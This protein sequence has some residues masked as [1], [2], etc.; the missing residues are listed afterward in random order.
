MSAGMGDEAPAVKDC[1]N[2]KHLM[3]CVSFLL[4]S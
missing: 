4:M 1:N 3:S 2:E